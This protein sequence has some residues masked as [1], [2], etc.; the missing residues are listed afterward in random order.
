MT[1]FSPEVLAAWRRCRRGANEKAETELN[2]LLGL[3]PWECS[4]A[5][6]DD[7]PSP[8]PPGTAGFDSWPRAQALRRQ[9]DEAA[10]RRPAKSRSR[11]AV[12]SDEG[13]PN[14]QLGQNGQPREEL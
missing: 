8:W 13:V 10:R 6:V 9:L 12:A 7:G 11:A 1:E 4:P 3:K 2:R 5:D 14:G